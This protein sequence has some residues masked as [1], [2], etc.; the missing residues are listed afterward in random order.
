MAALGG[1]LVADDLGAV[2]LSGALTAAAICAAAGVP[3][4]VSGLARAP[5]AVRPRRS[6]DSAR[7]LQR[8][9]ANGVVAGVLAGAG[10]RYDVDP[11]LLRVGFAVAAIVTG[12]LL[13][14]AYLLAWALLPAGTPSE[15]APPRRPRQGTTGN[16]LHLSIGVG[17]MTVAILLV[18]REL[19]LWWS[20][21]LVWPIALAAIGAALLWRQTRSPADVSVAGAVGEGAPDPGATANDEVDRRRTAIVELYR[22]GFG[23]ALVL[24]AALLFLSA[25]D[26]L[27]AARDAAFTAIVAIL[28][29]GL[30]LAPFIWRLGRNLAAERGER[31]RSQERAEM[32]AHLHDS[33]LQTLTLVQKRADDPREVAALARRQERELRNW[34]GAAPGVSDDDGFA[35]ALRRAAEEVEDA[36]RV[37]VEVVSV[38]DCAID[39]GSGAVVAAAREALTNAAKFA[40][41]GPISVYAEVS[42]D[43]VEVYVHD[44]GPGFDPDAIAPDRR[45]VTESIVGRMRRNGGTAT[46][47]SVPGSGTEVQL[48]VTRATP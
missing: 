14:L 10:D 46:I 28:A 34:L 17:L 15:P 27:G 21:A 12:G 44:R 16:G 31:I 9:R 48:S 43:R 33:V 37:K 39:E 36:H 1:L 3:A 42:D 35:A 19:G 8:D 22:G 11:I 5:D 6:R 26:A 7:R 24:G 25:N 2:A 13:L 38:G 41:D 30:I 23:I 4:V 45:G 47:R 18:F 32:A 40:D 20:D 29:L